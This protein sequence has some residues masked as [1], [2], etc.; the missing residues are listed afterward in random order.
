[1]KP[2]P[3]RIRKSHKVRPSCLASTLAVDG[4]KTRTPEIIKVTDGVYC[5]HGYALGNVLL[6]VTERSTVVIDTTESPKAACAVLEDLREISQLPISYIIYT[7]HHGDQTHGA[8][9]FHT[10]ETKVIAQ[11][12][13][14]QEIA[15]NNLFVPYRKRVTANQFVGVRAVSGAAP[16]AEL[17]SGC[18][19]PDITFDE[20]YRFEEGSVTF[21]LY[22]AEGET[23]DHLMVWLPQARCLF[24]G[25]LFYGYFPMLSSPMKPE[26]PVAAWADSLDRMRTLHAEYL[27]PSHGMPVAGAAK[28]EEMLANYGKAIRHVHDETV[29][30]IN[31][32]KSLE[33]SD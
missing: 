32:G 19:P 30:C 28:I 20:E 8:K 3:A 31:A 2:A 23:V 21:E 26:R 6:V 22:H 27:A 18:I 25:D 10:P 4:R 9:T 14:P 5:A 15:R 29:R 24:P 33:R 7:H 12:L 11:R 17:D 16:R 1:M 13:L